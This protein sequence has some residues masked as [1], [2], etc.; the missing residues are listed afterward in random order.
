M[1]KPSIDW[2]LGALLLSAI[3]LTQCIPADRLRVRSPGP[4]RF[5]IG[6]FETARLAPWAFDRGRQFP[7][8]RGSLGFTDGKTGRGALLRYDFSRGGAYV[9]AAIRLARPIPAAALELWV[10]SPTGIRIVAQVVD[11]TGQLLQYNLIRPWAATDPNG[12]YHHLVA[13]DGPSGH[14]FGANDGIPHGAIREVKVLAA[15]SME[16]SLA[17]AIAIDEVSLLSSV[18]LPHVDPFAPIVPA[19]SAVGDLMSGVGVNIHFTED[20]RALDIAAEA[21]FRWVRMDLVWRQVERE[22]GTYDFRAY[23]ELVSSLKRRGMRALLILDY[24]NPVHSDGP[25]HSP[26]SP[27]TVRAFGDFAAAAAVHFAGTGV[28]FE[29]W[30]EP[31]IFFWKPTPNAQHYSTLARESTARIRAGDSNALVA[32]GSLSQ[33]DFAFLRVMLESG[34]A[35][36]ADA[37]S[38][39]PY[40]K[41]AMWSVPESFW[42]ELLHLHTVAA[43]KKTQALPVWSSEW[44]YS[45]ATSP[46]ITRTV[47][48]RRQALFA[49]RQIL[50]TRIAGMPLSIYYDLRDDGT[51]PTDHESTCGLIANDYSD[52]PAVVAV[53]TLSRTARGRTLTGT[54]TIEPTA[55]RAVRFEAPASV[56]LILWAT[57]VEGKLGATIPIPESIVDIFGTPVVAPVEAGRMRLELTEMPLIAVFGRGAPMDGRR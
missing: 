13:L 49:V 38:V 34:A 39:H 16:R 5:V 32:V 11:A 27:R 25:D 53:R 55:I 37:L 21:G 51:D 3:S 7:G 40:R 23:D 22:P 15:D 43:E 56:A 2:R 6:D 28:V 50:A 1:R 52:K 48:E 46:A 54:L 44:G 35:E 8:A 36:G 17:G 18:P 41:D 33:I 20:D 14:W 42:E 57:S 24:E 45:S 31:N 9:A 26:Q 30:N 19:A 4:Q 29:V 10:R 12:W 47:A